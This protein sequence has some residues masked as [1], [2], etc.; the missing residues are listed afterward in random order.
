MGQ[1]R[2]CPDCGHQVSE[3]ASKCPQCGGP[4]WHKTAKEAYSSWS[5]LGLIDLIPGIRDLPYPVRFVIMVV[6]LLLLLLVVVP[7]VIKQRP[8]SRCTRRG[9]PRHSVSGERPMYRISRNGQEPVVDADQVEAIEPVMRS[10]NPGRYH[11]D[12][13]SADPLPSGHT[14][15]RWGVGIKRKDGSVVVEPDPW[16]TSTRPPPAA[17]G[18]TSAWAKSERVIGERP[19]CSTFSCL[20]RST[21]TAQRPRSSAW[22]SGRSI[23]SSRLSPSST[24]IRTQPGKTG[25]PFVP[26]AVDR[27]RSRTRAVSADLADITSSKCRACPD[28]PNQP[29]CK[30]KSLSLEQARARANRFQADLGLG[31]TPPRSRRH[32]C[33][34]VAAQRN[35]ANSAG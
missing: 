21:T 9:Q 27:S 25:V 30:S 16:N 24:K 20:L 32:P 29:A 33:Q 1:L 7:L 11:V 14:S 4:L 15:R 28:R 3:R 17:R 23:S 26:D 34:V 35:P 13:I 6:V 5:G 31:K 12:T 22:S 8:K 19:C 10:S 2:A 18:C